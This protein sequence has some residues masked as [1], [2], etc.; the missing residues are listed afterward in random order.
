MM[1]Y[2]LIYDVQM[3]IFQILPKVDKGRK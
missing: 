3:M 2:C 1:F